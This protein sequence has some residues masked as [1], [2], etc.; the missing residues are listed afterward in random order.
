MTHAP[1]T[2]FLGAR[3]KKGFQ[4]PHRQRGGGV[5]VHGV[6]WKREI[7]NMAPTKITSRS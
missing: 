4:K 6:R 5:G 7:M 1:C 2:V 3:L